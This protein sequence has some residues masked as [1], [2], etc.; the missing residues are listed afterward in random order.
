MQQEQPHGIEDVSSS[1]VSCQGV[2]DVSVAITET[3]IV[4]RVS[5]LL[6]EERLA[7]TVWV[8]R[9]DVYGFN[10]NKVV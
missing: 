6:C 9:L 8:Q 4:F 2:H 5:L 7:P 3:L 1:N 10:T